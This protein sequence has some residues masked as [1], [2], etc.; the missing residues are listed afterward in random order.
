MYGTLP[1]CSVNEDFGN[2]ATRA[3]IA[4]SFRKLEVGEAP[5][6]LPGRSRRPLPPERIRQCDHRR[7]HRPKRR[8]EGKHLS[9]VRKQGSAVFGSHPSALRKN[10]ATDHAAGIDERGPCC[11]PLEFRSDVPEVRAFRRRHPHPPDRAGG[12]AT[13]SRS[14][15]CLLFCRPPI[16]LPRAMDDI[17]SSRRTVENAGRKRGKACPAFPWDDPHG[18]ATRK[19]ACRRSDAGRC[20]LARS[21][22]GCRQGAAPRGVIVEMAP[23]AE[24]RPW[25]PSRSPDW[26]I[27]A[28]DVGATMRCSVRNGSDRRVDRSM[29]DI[30]AFRS[31]IAGCAPTSDDRR[32]PPEVPR[33][34]RHSLH[35]RR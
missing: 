32:L 2:F 19:I 35:V 6:G 23:I 28:L 7:D 18:A 4:R 30:R 26:T 33:D 24:Q 14:R 16:C 12:S 21:C 11:H 20:V 9:R 8:I 3:N 10:V 5:G 29:D 34:Q 22:R 31:K 15:S 13:L 1:S 25:E 27:G 17:S